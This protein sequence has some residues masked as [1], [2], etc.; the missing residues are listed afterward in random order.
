[1]YIEMACNE[2]FGAGEGGL[3][4]PTN[5]DRYFTLS[6]CEAVVFDRQVYRLIRDVEFLYNTAKVS[7]ILTVCPIVA[8]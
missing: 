4:N 3:I 1:M 5:P 6:C 8:A 2:M 7:C